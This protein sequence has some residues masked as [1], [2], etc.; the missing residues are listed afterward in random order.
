MQFSPNNFNWTYLYEVY[1]KVYNFQEETT[2]TYK[3]YV[4]IN[5][6]R[7]ELS[8][9]ESAYLLETPKSDHYST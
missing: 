3:V 8:H 5:D 2:K 9:L 7:D 4:Y 1:H 6:Q